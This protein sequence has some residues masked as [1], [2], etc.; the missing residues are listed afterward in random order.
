VQIEGPGDYEPVLDVKGANHWNLDDGEPGDLRV[1]DDGNYLKLGVALGGADEGHAG[2]RSEGENE[3]LRLG[4]GDDR[5]A[6]VR[7][8]GVL[9]GTDGGFDLGSGDAQWGRSTPTTWRQTT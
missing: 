4:V 8:S 5:V 3:L 7:G 9:P 2:I 1:G 6:E